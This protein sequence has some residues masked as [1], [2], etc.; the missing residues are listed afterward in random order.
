MREKARAGKEHVRESKQGAW[1]RVVL[2]T[3]MEVERVD[4]VVSPKPCG[5]IAEGL[6]AVAVRAVRGG[7]ARDRVGGTNGGGGGE[8]APLPGCSDG[9]RA[10]A[11]DGHRLRPSGANPPS[12]PSRWDAARTQRTPT[13]AS[14]AAAGIDPFTLQ[15]GREEGR[16]GHRRR[17]RPAALPHGS[18]EGGGDLVTCRGSKAG[19]VGE[20]EHPRFWPATA[21]ALPAWRECVTLFWGPSSAGYS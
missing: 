3:V 5:A 19:S 12:L 18:S 2:S 21:Q 15:P 11:R 6:V 16:G 1:R 10:G 17:R 4:S 7:G 9:S 20:V 8:S 13:R 14:G